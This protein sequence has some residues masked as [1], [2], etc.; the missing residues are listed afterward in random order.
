MTNSRAASLRLLPLCFEEERGNEKNERSTD[1]KRLLFVRKKFDPRDVLFFFVPLP[2]RINPSSRTD[3]VR[4]NQYK[5]ISRWCVAASDSLD[6]L[7]SVFLLV[8]WQRVYNYIF[9]IISSSEA[10]GSLP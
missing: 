5:T 6:D 10:H 9:A 4:K 8:P 1:K 7:L 3:P 2:E